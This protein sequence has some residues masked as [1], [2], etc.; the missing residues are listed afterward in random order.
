VPLLP[1]M[2]APLALW[3]RADHRRAATV[4]V[5]TLLGLSIVVQLPPV[6][7]EIAHARIASGKPSRP[8]HLLE[9]NSS[10]LVVTTRRAVAAV[11]ENIAY[12][13]GAMTPPSTRAREASL[14]ERVAFSLDFWWLYLVYLRALSLRAA[15]VVVAAM[16]VAAVALARLLWADLGSD[17]RSDPNS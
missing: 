17:P 7:V 15:L 1:L 3:R 12:L 13:S 8:E 5:A 4:A 2:I 14:A 11:P 10:P 9:W 16:A 6:S